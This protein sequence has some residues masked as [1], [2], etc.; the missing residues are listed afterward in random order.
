MA[1]EKDKEVHPEILASPIPIG[2]KLAPN[3]RPSGTVRLTNTATRLVASRVY[4]LALGIFHLDDDYSLLMR[5]YV[6]TTTGPIGALRLMV[7]SPTW[8]S[9]VMGRPR[10]FLGQSMSVPKLK[11]WHWLVSFVI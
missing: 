3:V 5:I 4:H 9:P 7:I 8:V 1:L 11:Q 10:P 2:N 6:G